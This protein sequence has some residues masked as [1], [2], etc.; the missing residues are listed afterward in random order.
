MTIRIV[1]S[2]ALLVVAAVCGGDGTEL[3]ESAAI[4]RELFV[5]TYVDLRVAAVTNPEGSIDGASKASILA[6]HGVTED[7]LLEFVDVHGV[8]VRYIRDVWNEVDQ[9]LEDLRMAQDSVGG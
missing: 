1:V 3:D 9:A 5:A 4:S 8:R 2:A 7:D 6:Q